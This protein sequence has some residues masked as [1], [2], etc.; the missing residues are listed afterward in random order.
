MPRRAQ[1]NPR[2]IR[3][4]SC[5]C[6]LCTAQ[7]RPGAKA[8]RRDCTGPWQARYRDPTGTQ[9]S[10]NFPTKAEA[11]AFLDSTRSRIRAG[12]YHDPKRGQITL[13]QLWAK[14]RPGLI[15][16]ANTLDSIDYFWSIV[17]TRWGNYRLCD[18]EHLDV[19]A[20]L[21]HMI[22]E[23]RAPATANRAVGLLRRLLEIAVKDG[24]RIP[25]NPAEGI[26]RAPARKKSPEDRRPPSYEQLGTIRAVM[27][28]QYHEMLIVVEETG[29]RWGE[30]VGLRRC[31]VDMKKRVLHVRHVVEEVR[32][33]LR[34]KE[35]PKTDEGYRTIPLT[36]RA[37]GALQAVQERRPASAARTGVDDGMCPEELIFRGPTGG[38]LRR[39][40]FR[41]VYTR[42]AKRVGIARKVKLPNGRWEWWPTI[43]DT[44]GAWASRLHD[45]GLPEAV[46]QR[47]LGHKRA[48]SVTWLYTHASEDAIEQGRAALEGRGRRGGHLRAVGE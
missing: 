22:A 20:W 16:E 21:A 17:E 3:V 33:Q 18:I 15:R 34:R 8:T 6:A 47:L 11:E 37:I 42:A 48:S 13:T 44:R 43:H 40:T 39:G 30:L 1:N 14:W 25:Y 23:G 12:E 41:T 26:E 32:G 10:R 27:P 45:E 4:K 7:H 5:G 35:Y 36:D 19:Q 24:R 28:R 2:Q 46:V 31:N 38:P 29:L 9:K